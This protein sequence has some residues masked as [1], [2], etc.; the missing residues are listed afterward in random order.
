VSVNEWRSYQVG[1]NQIDAHGDQKKYFVSKS[2]LIFADYDFEVKFNSMLNV[3]VIIL[4]DTW[5][6]FKSNIYQVFKRPV[7]DDFVEDVNIW[8]YFEGVMVD[9]ARRPE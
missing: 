4:K 8:I 6:E 1:A 5:Y 2:T 3:S 9:E 7:D